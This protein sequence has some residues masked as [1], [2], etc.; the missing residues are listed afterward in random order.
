[1]DWQSYFPMVV[2][3]K[4]LRQRSNSLLCLLIHRR[5]KHVLVVSE[6]SHTHLHSLIPGPV[7]PSYGRD[8]TTYGMTNHSI[9]SLLKNLA[10]ALQGI[11][12]ELAR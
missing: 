2:R 9:Y 12:T 3:I 8:S 11:A 6:W 1:M 5:E 7:N 10:P 4:N